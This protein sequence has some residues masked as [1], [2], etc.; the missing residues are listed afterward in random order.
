MVLSL[1]GRAPFGKTAEGTPRLQ[2]LD[3]T[4]SLR[5]KRNFLAWKGASLS[6]RW[7]L[8]TRSSQSLPVEL[9][10]VS[11]PTQVAW[12]GLTVPSIVIVQDAVT[13]SCSRVCDRM[14]NVVLTF[15][16]GF[17]RGFCAFL[18]TCWKPTAQLR[19]CSSAPPLLRW[20]CRFS[21]CRHG[22]G[23]LRSV[24]R[25]RL[26]AER[27]IPQAESCEHEPDH[28]YASDDPC[29]CESITA[30]VAPVEQVRQRPLQASRDWEGAHCRMCVII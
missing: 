5:V 3:F 10:K 20:I 8:C 4:V 29:C 19:L 24:Q 27:R 1:H 26:A 15:L 28:W 16:N 30:A 2:Q 21:L 13:A 7:P 23:F 6:N 12:Q 22:S 9:V 25:P 11:G 14:S 18:N 17:P